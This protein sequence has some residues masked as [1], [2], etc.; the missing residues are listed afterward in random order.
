VRLSHV[1][2]DSYAKNTPKITLGYG[3]ANKLTIAYKPTYGILFVRTSSAL[4]RNYCDCR[5]AVNTTLDA[6]GT[7]MLINYNVITTTVMYA[8]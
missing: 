6:V 7:N 3:I 4:S 2:E 5:G 8:R 1:P